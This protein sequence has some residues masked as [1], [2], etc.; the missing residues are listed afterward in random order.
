MHS[1]VSNLLAQSFGVAVDQVSDLS[2]LYV[3]P[4]VVFGKFRIHNRFSF[5]IGGGFQIA[6]T[7]FHPTN[8]NE[9][10]SIRFP[11]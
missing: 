2:L 9:I 8:H 6:A 4:G 7:S 5:I 11:F 3:T 10:L 1:Y